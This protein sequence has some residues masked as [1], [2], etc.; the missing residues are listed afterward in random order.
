MQPFVQMTEMGH[1]Q[2][3]FCRDDV[4]GLKAII[5]IHDTTLGPAL[6]GCRLYDYASEQDALTDVLRLSRG[7]TYKAAVAGLDLGGGKSVIIGDPSIKSEAL[8]RAFGRHIES[9]NGRYYTAE[10][11]NT[12]VRDMDFIRR[13]TRFVTGAG[14]HVGGSGDPSPVTAW[15]VFHG[16]RACLEVKFGSPSVEG[17]KI[18]IQGLGNV[19]RHLAGY[20]HERGAKLVFSDINARRVGEMIETY[21][22]SAVEG[23]AFYTADVDVLAPCAIGGIV[24]RLTIPGIKAPIVCGGA[25]NILGDEVRDGEALVERGI[26]YAPDYVVNAGGLINVYSEL[27]RWPAQKAMEDAAEIFNTTKAILNRAANEGIT[28]TAASNRIAEDRIAKVAHIKRLYAGSEGRDANTS[29]AI[30]L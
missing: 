17:R 9:L 14:A 11:M 22:G 26:V 13:E 20:L 21:G 6:G 12:N 25:N 27:K 7:M 30:P 16:I 23:D 19:G 5:A 4:V 18:A 24:N 15:G 1:E 3:L 8:F 2:V 29:A 10:D 28:T